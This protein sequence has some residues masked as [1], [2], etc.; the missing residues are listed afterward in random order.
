MQ[1]RWPAHVFSTAMALWVLTAPGAST[2]RQDWEPVKTS[3][4]GI[5][6]S[7][8]PGRTS[9]FYELRFVA[10]A[11]VPPDRFEARVWQ[12][13]QTAR[14]PVQQ[15]DFLVRKPAELVFHDRIH[16]SVVSDREYTMRILRER[17]GDVLRMS[18]RTAPEL[19]PPPTE[20]YVT[21]PLVEGLWEFH[22]DGSGTRVVYTVYSEPG[23]SIAAWLVR[24]AQQDEALEDF[25]HALKEA[26]R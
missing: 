7:R 20:G 25:R 17:A 5:E 10:R 18:F 12:G 24:G 15:R 19:G 16:V 21:L 26:G 8:R 14:K 9:G 4:D 11:E 3:G 2:A 6:V 1:N 13:F 23:G 22:P